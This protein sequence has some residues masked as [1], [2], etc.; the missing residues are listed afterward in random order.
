MQMH[1][2]FHGLS[3]QPGTEKALPGVFCCRFPSLQVIAD[4]QPGTG[5]ESRPFFDYLETCLRHKSEMVIFEAARAICSLKDV[6]SREL[7]PAVT[8]LQLFL[9]SSKPVLRFAAVRMLNK[10]W[11]GRIKSC[12]SVSETNKTTPCSVKSFAR[13]L[14][15]C[16]TSNQAARPYVACQAA[17]CG[18]P[19]GPDLLQQPRLTSRK[20]E[21]SP[22]PCPRT[23]GGIS[24]HCPWY[25]VANL[26]NSLPPTRLMVM[27]RNWK[28]I[29]TQPHQVG[30]SHCLRVQPTEPPS[31]RKEGLLDTT[32]PQPSLL[33]GLPL[34][35]AKF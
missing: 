10:V 8:V 1:A 30:L 6:T 32:C 24:A 19:L 5:T 21:L 16:C 4:S 15:E 12:V 31:P 17:V 28:P 2:Q 33:E 13:A 27:H 23:P 7:S 3:T 26:C 35:K 25:M 34:P 11:V 29:T 9:S 20:A 22:L 18:S 14:K